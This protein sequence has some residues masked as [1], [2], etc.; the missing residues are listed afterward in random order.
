MATPTPQSHAQLVLQE[1]ARY[2]TWKSPVELGWSKKPKVMR[3]I[4]SEILF[5]VPHDMREEVVTQ[6]GQYAQALSQEPRATN[7]AEQLLAIL[8]E[9]YGHVPSVTN[10][11]ASGEFRVGAGRARRDFRRKNRF[12]WRG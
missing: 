9:I 3:R 6:L 11:A 10:P 4:L 2:Q 12:S 8:A 1:L 5:E 7:A